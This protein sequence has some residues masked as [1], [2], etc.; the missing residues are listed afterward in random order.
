[1]RKFFSR[2]SPLRE[3]QTAL[4]QAKA[5]LGWERTVMEGT[6]FIRKQGLRLNQGS[7]RVAA[8]V[9]PELRDIYDEYFF[10]VSA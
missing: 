4:V 9:E 2:D 3:A 1:M 8:L 6:E 5:R 10:G 7:R